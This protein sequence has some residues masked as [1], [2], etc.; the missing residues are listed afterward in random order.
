MLSISSFTR[1]NFERSHYC[2]NVEMSPHRS[3]KRTFNQR[4]YSSY[5]GRLEIVISFVQRNC[6]FWNLLNDFK[7]KK[8]ILISCTKFNQFF[9]LYCSQWLFCLFHNNNKLLSSFEFNINVLVYTL[10]VI[11]VRH[12]ITAHD[13]ECGEIEYISVTVS[14]WF[15]SNINYWVGR[16][17][18][19]F[20]FFSIKPL[21]IIIFNKWKHFIINCSLLIGAKTKTNEIFILKPIGE[22]WSMIILNR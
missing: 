7:K 11:K 17:L 4:I 18:L 9:Y 15:L 5:S 13:T 16:D 2:W 19:R 20:L 21:T 1:S 3:F 10:K 6:S 8:N 12:F 22:H 14:V